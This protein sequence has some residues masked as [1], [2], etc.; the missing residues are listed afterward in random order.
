[1]PDGVALLDPFLIRAVGFGSSSSEIAGLDRGVERDVWISWRPLT[2]LAELAL[3]RWA[4]VSGAAI[5]VEPG[6][7]LHPE[8]FAWA[9]PT[10]VSG[11]AAELLALADELERLA[12][13]LFRRRWWRQR[14]ERL[15]FLLVEGEPLAPE[16]RR[17]EERW[18]A[19]SPHVAP[20]CVPFPG[21][22]LV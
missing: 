15:R 19:L 12:P 8:L 3:A 16:L 7:R 6:P 22:A 9:R 13:R 17:V 2:H 18:R 4:V 21:R 10:V 20:R 5:L 1:M 14:G 11:S